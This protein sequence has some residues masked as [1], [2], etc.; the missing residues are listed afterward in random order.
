M[1]GDETESFPDG[2]CL[3]REGSYPKKVF[4]CPERLQVAKKGEF[5]HTVLGTRHF[6]MISGK[7]G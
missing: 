6:G 1:G 7:R 2:K 4:G 5:R 3:R